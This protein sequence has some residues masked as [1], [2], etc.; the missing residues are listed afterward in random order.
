MK[1]K[2]ILHDWKPARGA[3]ALLTAM[4]CAVLLI[5][6]LR[7]AYADTADIPFTE[8]VGEKPSDKGA[9]EDVPDAEVGETEA[10]AEEAPAEEAGETKAPAADESAEDEEFYEE[11]ADSP[12]LFGASAGVE[13]GD[14][15]SYV[16][17]AGD[18]EDETYSVPEGSA[19]IY[20]IGQNV[21]Y[22]NDATKG[23]AIQQGI[24]AALTYI[25]GLYDNDDESTVER[26]ATIVVSKGTYENGIDIGAESSSELSVSQLLKDILIK[27]SECDASDDKLT[28]R[29]VA[30]DAV[31]WNDDGTIAGFNSSSSGEV[32]LEGNVDVIADDMNL[33][34][35]LAGLYYSTRGLI[36]A[37]GLDSLSVIGTEKD[38]YIRINASDISES[39]YV[40]TGDGDD[41]VNMIVSSRADVEADITTVIQI[42]AALRALDELDDTSITEKLASIIFPEGMTDTEQRIADALDKMKQLRTKL[43]ESAYAAAKTTVSVNA[44]SGSDIIDIILKDSTRIESE[45]ITGSDITATLEDGTVVPLSY[46]TK[47]A[48]YVDTGAFELNVDGGSG[49]DRI[50]ISGERDSSNAYPLAKAASEYVLDTIKNNGGA[51]TESSISILGGAGDDVITVDNSVMFSTRGTTTVTTAGGSGYDRLHL[52]GRLD[53]NEEAENRISYKQLGNGAEFT[54][55][56]LA[57]IT[58]SDGYTNIDYNLGYTGAYTIIASDMDAYTDTLENKRTVNIKDIAEGIKENAESFTNYV[59][60]VGTDKAHTVDF[61]SSDYILVEDGTRLILSNIYVIGGEDELI[62][63]KKLIAP[64]F[65]IIIDGDKIEIEGQ[66]SGSSIL[67]NAYAEDKAIVEIDASL[68]VDTG[69]D[70]DGLP[71]DVGV[72]GATVG[73][74][75]EKRSI[76]INVGEQAKILADGA[77]DIMARLY[78]YHDFVP[79][80]ELLKKNEDGSSSIEFNPVTAKE[81][82][83]NIN[84]GGTIHAR[85]SIHINADV[86]IDIDVTNGELKVIIPIAIGVIKGEAKINVYG[87]AD[88]RSGLDEADIY[89]EEKADSD[90]LPTHDAGILLRADGTMRITAHAGAGVLKFNVSIAAAEFET[91]V[92]VGG[93]ARLVAGDS[94]RL[95]AKSHLVTGVSSVGYASNKFNVDPQSGVFISGTIIEL[96]SS[97]AVNDKASITA[98]LGDVEISSISRVSNTTVSVAIPTQTESSK[99]QLTVFK[100]IDL[101]KKLLSSGSEGGAL[102]S[103]AEKAGF[104]KLGELFTKGTESSNEDGKQPNQLLGA[105]AFA[106][107]NVGSTANVETDG[108]IEAKK[109]LNVYSLSEVRSE[110][111]A[112]GSLYRTPNIV[113]SKTFEEVPN[114][115]IGAGL[116]LAIVENSASSA[117]KK[118]NVNAG[119]LNISAQLGSSESVAVAKSGHVPEDKKASLGIAGAISV[120]IA[121]FENGAL[122]GKD[123]VCTISDGGSINVTALGTGRFVT[124]GDASGKRMRSMVDMGAVK[125]P[126]QSDYNGGENFKAIGAGIAVDVIN[127]D[128]RAEIED[129]AIIKTA[130]GRLGG[131][132]MRAEFSGTHHIEAA[133]GAEGGTS[134]IPVLSLSLSGVNVTAYIGSD[135]T[136]AFIVTDGDINVNATNNMTRTLVA[137]AQAAGVKVGLGAA[138]GIIVASDNVEASLCRSVNALGNVYVDAVSIS[139]ISEDVRASARGIKP[140]SGSGS[141]GQG[142]GTTGSATQEDV[143]KLISGNTTASGESLSVGGVDSTINKLISTLKGLGEKLP[144]GKNTNLS[145]STIDSLG[146]SRPAAGTSEGNVQA[147]AAVAVNVFQNSVSSKIG[148]GT[149]I[150]A[151]KNVRASSKQDSDSAISANG[152]AVRAKEGIGAAVAVNYIKY[153]NRAVVRA[154]KVSAGGSILVSAS[155]EEDEEK[156]AAEEILSDLVKYFANQNGIEVLLD[157][158]AKSQNKTADELMDDLIKEHH[159]DYASLSDADKKAVADE[160]T[161]MLIA[162]LKD[163]P[164]DTAVTLASDIMD[165][166]L[167]EFTELFSIEF[168]IDLLLDN[169]DA[170]ATLEQKFNELK[171]DAKMTLASLRELISSLLT[172]KFGNSSEIDGIGNRISTVAISGEGASNVGVA[173]SVAVTNVDGETLA[174]ISERASLSDDDI[175]SDGTVTVKSDSADKVYTTATASTVANGAPDKNTTTDNS[176]NKSIGIG[177]S[178]ALSITNTESNAIIGANRSIVASALGVKAYLQND[179]DTIA[180]AGQDPIGAQQKTAETT[181][182]AGAAASI[183]DANNSTP[184]DIAADAAVAITIADNTV[185]A[186]VQKGKLNLT[187]GNILNSE[188]EPSKAVNGEELQNLIA[189][190]YQRGQTMTVSSGFA[191]AKKAAVGASV[192]LNI[193]SSDVAA[194]LEGTGNIKG[195]ILVDSLTFNE[196]EVNALAVVTGVNLDRYLSK[197]RS[198]VD[199]GNTL[200]KPSTGSINAMAMNKINEKMGKGSENDANSS[201]PISASLLQKLNIKTPEV[202]GDKKASDALE[203]NSGSTNGAKPQDYDPSGNGQSINI[204][205]AVGVNITNHKSTAK[206]NGDFNVAKAEIAS[207]N[208]GNFRT[209]GSGATITP[210]TVGSNNIAAGVAVSVNNNRTNAIL[211]GKLDANG[212]RLTINAVSTANMDGKYP[213]LMAAQALAG[214]V[215]GSGGKVGL[216]GA[217]AVTV[218]Q[219]EI[220]AYTL[221]NTELYAGDIAI[222]ANDKSKLAVRAGA[223]SVN[224]STVGMGASFA[225]LYADNE[226]GAAVGNNNSVTAESLTINAERM[227]VTSDDYKFPFDWDTLFTANVADD[228]ANNKGLININ[229]SDGKGNGDDSIEVNLSFDDLLKTVDMLNYLTMTNYYVE[230]IAGGISTGATAKVGLAGGVSMIYATGKTAAQIGNNSKIELGGK[231]DM[232]A[233]SDITVR[234]IGGSVGA[235]MQAGVGVNMAG[236]VNVRERT[237]YDENGN[238]VKET[239]S[240]QTLATV[241]RSTSISAKSGIDIDASAHIELV[242]ATVAAGLAAGNG[243]GTTGGNLNVIATGNTVRAAVGESSELTSEKG[244]VNVHANNESLLLPVAASVTGGSAKVAAGGT[245]STIVT[246]NVTEAKLGSGVTVDAFESVSIKAESREKLINWLSSTSA[247]TGASVAGTIG[248]IVSGSKTLAEVGNNATVKSN[249]GSIEVLAN[250][251]VLQVVVLTAATVSGGGNLAA[252]ATVNVSVFEREVAAYVGQNASLVAGALS[253]GKNV[254]IVANG[255]DR[256]YLITAAGSAGTSSTISGN[257][258]TVV[259]KSTVKAEADSSSYIEAGDTVVIFAD[260]DYRIYDIAPTVAAGTGTASVGATAST[261]VATNTVKANVGS[262]ATIIA[263]A[264]SNAANGGYT[265][266]NKRRRG[267][268]VKANAK[269][270]TVKA[271]VGVAATGGSVAVAGVVSTFVSKNTVCAAVDTGATLI[272]GFESAKDN[273]AASGEDAEASAEADDD[274]DL[275]IVAGAIGGASST[276]VGASVVTVVMNRS[277]TASINASTVRATGSVNAAANAE[278]M[279]V[280]ASLNVSGA[281]TASVAAGANTL[282]YNND[283]K[284]YLTGSIYAK[285]DVKVSSYGKVDL[286]LAAGCAGG[287]GTVAVTGGASALVFKNNVT[288]ELG[289]TV[290]ADNI[291]VD[292]QSDV[293]LVNAAGAVGGAGTAGITPVAVVTYYNGT[294]QAL[295]S[296]GS[297]IDAKGSFKLNG[298]S[299]ETVT[300][301]A[302]GAAIAGTAGV[303]GTVAVS[304]TKQTTRAKAGS[305]VS[306]SASAIDV[307]ALDTSKFITA[308]GSVAGAGTT[309][310]G[311]VA[312]VTIMH[313]TVEAALTGGSDS[314]KNAVTSRTGS[315]NITADAKRDIRAYA[316]DVAGSGIA[317]VSP[318]VMVLVTGGKMDK[319]SAETLS[320]GFSGSDFNTALFGDGNEYTKAY[321]MDDLDEL[322]SGEQ[323]YSDIQIGDENGKADF[324][325]GYRSDDFDNDDFDDNTNTG[326]GENYEVKPEGNGEISSVEGILNEKYSFNPKDSV[327]ALVGSGVHIVS[328]LDILVSAKDTVQAEMFNASVAG[329]GVAAVGVGLSTAVLYSNVVAG[330]DEGAAL[331]ADGDIT[332]SAYSGSKEYENETDDVIRNSAVSDMLSG[333]SD[334]E[335]DI[336]KR[337]IRVVSISASGSGIAGVAVAGSALSLSNITTAYMNADVTR[338]NELCVSAASLYPNTIA[339]NGSIGGGTV[340]VSAS[341]AVAVT[342]GEVSASIGGN[343]S[344]TNVSK[345]NVTTSAV[346]DTVSASAAIS[347]GAAAVNG[348]IAV[349]VNRMK[350][351]TY[352]GNAVSISSAKEVNVSAVNTSRGRAYILGVSGGGVGA[353][354][355]AAVV[356]AS[357]EINTYVGAKPNSSE[358]C[359]N[360]VAADK[361]SIT[362]TVISSA[363]PEVIMASGGAV[364]ATGTVLAVVNNTKSLAAILKKNVTAKSID[365]SASLTA[366]AEASFDSATIG[367]TAM[368]ASIA[369]VGLNSKNEATVDTTG[370]VISVTAGNISVSANGTTNAA[371]QSAVVSAGSSTINGNAAIVDNHSTNTAEIKGGSADKTELDVEGNVNVTATGIATANAKITG[372]SLAQSSTVNGSFAVAVLRNAQRAAIEAG[373]INANSVSVTSTLNEVDDNDENADAKKDTATATIVAG[374]GT[375][376]VNASAN[377]AVAYGKSESS[378]EIKAKRIDASGSV[379]VA[380]SGNAGALAKIDSMNVGSITGAFMAGFAYAQGKF[381]AVIDLDE[382]AALNANTVNV[383]AKDILTRAN[384]LVTPAGK[385][386]ASIIGIKTNLAVAIA[387]AK[388]NALIRGK[389][390]VASEGNVSVLAQSTS[391]AKAAINKPAVEVSNATVA[392]NVAV[393]LLKTE[394]KAAAGGNKISAPKATLSVVSRLNQNYS[395]YT[396]LATA[397]GNKAAVAMRSAKANAI[398]AR[399]IA[400]NTASIE[401][402]VDAN[403][404]EVKAYGKS[405]AYAMPGSAALEADFAG[406]G[407]NAVYAEA[408]GTF[409]AEIN[410]SGKTVKAGTG[411]I[412]MLNEYTAKAKA[413]SGQPTGGIKASISALNIKTNVAE[414]KS[415]VLASTVISAGN[416]ESDGII[417]M[418]AK[419]TATAEA[420][421]NAS[422]IEIS[423][424]TVAVNVV[425]ATLE[426]EQNVSISGGS[427]SAEGDITLDSEFNNNATEYD[428]LATVGSNS[429]NSI[430]IAYGTIKQNTADANVKTEVSAAVS[431]GSV[432]TKGLLHVKTV[433]RSRA[434]ANVNTGSEISAK[435]VEVLVTNANALGTFIAQAKT[436]DGSITASGVEVLV[437]SVTKAYASTSV[438]GDLGA[439][440]TDVSYNTA[441]SDTSST[442]SAIFGGNGTIKGNVTVSATGNVTSVAETQHPTISVSMTRIAATKT[443]AKLNAVQSAYVDNT[444]AMSVHGS[445]DIDSILTGNASSD[446]GGAQIKNKNVV[447][448]GFTVD[449]VSMVAADVNESSAISSTSNKAY[450]TS[451]N[452]KGSVEARTVSID[453]LSTVN[454]SSTTKKGVDLALASVGGLRSSA[455]TADSVSAYAEKIAIDADDL[456]INANGVAT[457]NAESNALGSASA[458]SASVSEVSAGVG[459]G[460]GERNAETGELKLGTGAQTV[461]AG[462]GDNA[463]ITLSGDLTVKAINKGTAKAVLIKGL[464]ISVL[465]FTK[466]CLPTKS[467]YETEAYIGNGS[468]INVGGNVTVE[469]KDDAKATSEA[470]S[471]DIAFS[472]SVT[473][474]YGSNTVYAKNTAKVGTSSIFAAKDIVIKSF[475]KADM[476]A[477]TVANSSG[478]FTNEGDLKAENKLTRSTIANV[479]DGASIESDFGNITVLAQSGTED[480][481]STYAKLDGLAFTDFKHTRAETAIDSE[482]RIDIGNAKITDT[483]GTVQIWADASLDELNT[484]GYAY[485]SG[486]GAE[487]NAKAKDNISLRPVVTIKGSGSYTCEI[488]ARNVEIH[489][490]TTKLG[491]ESFSEAS[492]KAFGANVDAETDLDVTLDGDVTIE[493][494]RL[495]AY[496][497]LNVTASSAPEYSTHNIFG[498]SKIFL[499]AIGHGVA[500][501]DMDIVSNND[502]TVK[503]GVAIHGASV[504]LRGM[505]YSGTSDY[506]RDTSGFT[507]KQKKGNVNR[508][509]NAGTSVD[510]N[511]RFYIGDAAAGIVIDI[512]ESEGKTLVRQVGIKDEKSIWIISADKV[513]I[514]RITNNKAGSL[515]MDVTS[516]KYEYVYDQSY[517]PY[518][519]IVNRTDKTVEIGGVTV[520]NDNFINPRVTLLGGSYT[521]KN[522]DITR[523][524]VSVTNR[525]SGSVSITGL[526]ANPRGSVAFE[527]VGKDKSGNALGGSLTSVSAITNNSSGTLTAPIWAHSL[528]IKGAS[529]V[530]SSENARFAL[531]LITY[532]SNETDAELK[533]EAT[534]SID[535]SGDVFIS[536]T[537]ILMKVVSSDDWAK[538]QPSKAEFEP[539]MSIE[540]IESL[541]KVDV[542]LETGKRVY[543]L[544]GTT[545]VTMPIPGT[546]EYVSDALK[547]LSQSVTIADRDKLEYYLESYDFAT[548]VSIYLLPNGTRIYVDSDGE[549]IRIR[550]NNIDFGLADYKYDPTTNTVTLA[551]GV[552][553]DL[554]NGTLSVKEGYSYEALL[555]AISGN[556]LMNKANGGTF[557]FI[558]LDPEV[559]DKVVYDENGNITNKDEFEGTAAQVTTLT[560]WYE[561]NGIVYFYASLG[562]AAGDIISASKGTKNYILAYDAAKDTVKAYLLSAQGSGVNSDVN[563]EDFGFEVNKD[564]YYTKDSDKSTLDYWGE[565]SIDVIIRNFPDKDKNNNKLYDAENKVINTVYYVVE[566]DD[567]Y[568]PNKSYDTVYTFSQ[569]I[570]VS[571]SKIKYDEAS[572]KWYANSK[573]LAEVI[574]FGSGSFGISP[575]AASKTDDSELKAVYEALAGMYWKIS[576]EDGASYRMN[577]AVITGNLDSEN[578]RTYYSYN[579]NVE[580]PSYIN[581]TTLYSY[582][583]K[584]TYA[585]L[586]EI[587]LTLTPAQTELDENGDVIANDYT[588]EIRFDASS[589]GGMTIVG[590]TDGIVVKETALPANNRTDS[591]TAY[592]ITSSLYI[593]KSTDASENG[594]ALIFATGSD[595]ETISMANGK[596]AFAAAYNSV[597]GK[598]ESETVTVERLASATAGMNSKITIKRYDTSNGATKAQNVMLESVTGTE[599]GAVAKDI[600]GRYYIYNSSDSTWTLLTSSTSYAYNQNN[601]VIDKT[602]DDKT[603]SATVAT[604][605]IKQSGSTVLT[606]KEVKLELKFICTTAEG[607]LAMRTVNGSDEYYILNNGKWSSIQKDEAEQLTSSLTSSSNT[608]NMTLATYVIFTD[609]MEVGSDGSVTVKNK[610]SLTQRVQDVSGIKYNMGDI[611]GSSVT[612][613]MKDTQGSIID[614]NDTA[615]DKAMN[616]TA[617]KGDI[618]FVSASSGSIGT[619]DNPLELSAKGQIRYKNLSGKDSLETDTF[620]SGDGDI[621]LGDIVVDGLGELGG[622]KLYIST[623]SGKISFGSM[624]VMRGG[625]VKLSAS[626]D[627]VARK[628]INITTAVAGEN[629][630]SYASLKGKN[631]LLDAVNLYDNSRLTLEANEKVIIDSLTTD[632]H[633]GKAQVNI[634]AGDSVTVDEYAS[635][636]DSSVTVS[637]DED[638]VLG[639]N[640]TA[641]ASDLDID[642]K[643]SI[644]LKNADVKRGSLDADS[645][646]DLTFGIIETENNT[647]KLSAKGNIAS[648]LENGYIYFRHGERNATFTLSANGNIGA[649]ERYLVTDTDSTVNITLAHDYYIDSVELVGST[650]YERT[651]RSV[652]TSSGRDELGAW[653]TGELILSGA[654]K[655]T[656]YGELGIDANEAIADMVVSREER[657]NWIDILDT[658]ALMAL[659]KDGSITRDALKE[660]IGA[661]AASKI[662]SLIRLGDTVDDEKGE[663]GYEQLAKLLEARLG[664]KD[665]GTD[666]YIISDEVIKAYLTLSMNLDNV[667]I[668]RMA[669]IL[670]GIVNADE[671]AEMIKAAWDKA[672]YGKH[673]GTRP[674]D[675]EP[676]EIRIIVGESTGAAYVKNEGD[677]I[678]H[679]QNGT[680][681]AGEVTSA[682]GNVTVAAALGAVE[683]SGEGTANITGNVIDISAKLGVGANTQLIID[684]QKLDMTLVANVTKPTDRADTLIKP[685]DEN[686]M[687]TSEANKTVSPVKGWALE[688]EI[689]YDWIRAKNSECATRLNIAAGGDINVAEDS[690]DL[691]LG[692]IKTSNGSI[693][694][695]AQGSIVDTREN[696][697][698]PNIAANGDVQLTSKEGGI[699]TEN[700]RINTDIG[701]T[702]HAEA[703]DDISISDEGTLDMV[704]D[705]EQGQINAD[706]K[707]DLNLSNTEGDLVIGPIE[708][709]GTVTIVSEG[710]IVAGDKYD[711]EAQIKANTIILTAKGGIGTEDEAMSVDTDGENGGT[712]SAKGEYINITEVNGKLILKNIDS[713]T[714][715]V[716][717][718]RGD[719]LDGN[720]AICDDAVEAQKEANNARAEADAAEADAFVKSEKAKR[721]RKELDKAKSESDAQNAVV[722]ELERQLDDAREELNNT[723]PADT[724]KVKELN[725]RIEKLEKQLDE[726]KNRQAQL[727]DALDKANAENDAAQAE[728]DKANANAEKLR[729]EAEAKQAEADRIKAEAEN[730][731]ATVNA[732]NDVTISA[733]GNIGEDGHGV[734]ISAGGT[735][736]VSA[737]ADVDGDGTPDGNGK[738]IFIAGKGDIDISDITT[739][740]HV[741]IA[742]VG[743]S[744]SG[745]GKITADSLDISSV[746]GDVGSEDAPIHTSVD[747]LDAMGENVY[748]HND[749]DTEIGQISA[750]DNIKLDSD[751]DVTADSTAKPNIIAADTTINASGDIGTADTPLDTSTGAF[752]GTADDIYIN[753]HTKDLDLSDIEADKLD[754]DTDGNVTGK[755][756]HVKD[757]T[758][759]ADGYVGSEDDPFTFEASGKTDIN[760]DL[761][762]WYKNLYTS[763]E[764]DR[765]IVT[766]VMRFETRINGE[767]YNVYA[768]IRVDSFGG[769]R[770][771]GF[772]LNKGD[773][774]EVFWYKVLGLIR[775]YLHITDFGTFVFCSEDEA[776]FEN[777]AAWAKLFSYLRMC[778]RAYGFGL[779][780][781]N[782]NDMHLDSALKEAWV[783]DPFAYFGKMTDASDEAWAKLIGQLSEELS[784]FDASVNKTLKGGFDSPKELYKA[785]NECMAAFTEKR[786]A[787][788]NLSRPYSVGIPA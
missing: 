486:L 4:L 685:I 497:S 144:V 124:V 115:A 432:N 135:P 758:I 274:S 57:D 754:V 230:A 381:N 92:S 593:K 165:A 334:S 32:L 440:Y 86:D 163:E 485:A 569:F 557:S 414:A 689:A 370:A 780:V 730:A 455:H 479:A 366:E 612:V 772:F 286:A 537:P 433:G 69:L 158:A 43:A 192:A 26:V 751:G 535:A 451:S 235:S 224:G 263:H 252:G 484:Y 567:G 638:V 525:S 448:S 594:M 478:G 333:V 620:I 237:Y 687:P 116:A 624:D 560:K 63:V 719:I 217:V 453:A 369:Y 278:D 442:T 47:L 85:G 500:K 384:A 507:V 402:G 275:Y 308:V 300:T 660:Y 445:V 301:D 372:I 428:A 183:K 167:N 434:K 668:D 75:E 174:E 590:K 350:A 273:A 610:E 419:G 728:A 563:R 24:E 335:L 114:K 416:V 89:N 630:Y 410:A 122:I 316:L 655:D 259:S 521:V 779:A 784:A 181:P 207:T 76:Y 681:T 549:I 688:V 19:Y 201:L 678:I 23:N 591:G 325:S 533:K 422:D 321:A 506:K 737:G 368:G 623:E 462:I 198:I 6:P 775:Y 584:F 407:V 746:G 221:E 540:H 104:D 770:L 295:V 774:D 727:N 362:N 658:P 408:A 488:T 564:N 635:L 251:D 134:I 227:K 202:S 267:I 639:G 293:L 592:R 64:D 22:N 361:L 41:T 94:A 349:S 101:V 229:V 149:V 332:V 704:A 245:L 435:N 120:H 142:D 127:V 651:K 154:N 184:D 97:A 745:N 400:K 218:A 517:I 256:A 351:N 611:T 577:T 289:G 539:S 79:G 164:A 336:T 562:T 724:A 696:E 629:E 734:S 493:N 36:D 632:G 464:G 166:I 585:S 679:Q 615:T 337:T 354:V 760:G 312:S 391:Y 110:V 95:I 643:G 168:F 394:Q 228:D 306:I 102:S 329:S 10:P 136:G 58:I 344:I 436:T 123:A 318:T 700:E 59:V 531:W 197:L 553:F 732:E 509:F 716:I 565:G 375:I 17:G 447:V 625:A 371:A 403:R 35:M 439:G 138:V 490:K 648:T 395:S 597:M 711:R 53:K 206:V 578:N 170:R 338:A 226:I 647:L 195:S 765:S 277:V 13:G 616:I 495:R 763:M 81:G 645:G 14:E 633:G 392:A 471:K 52:S 49:D 363:K 211:G 739:D 313:N 353:G 199:L 326:R 160:V 34:L 40:D 757:I 418:D 423:G 768:L 260:L 25:K 265:I 376:G 411:G 477:G 544:E 139:R 609:G 761:G 515:T 270:L 491:I 190:A 602:T 742:T 328:A 744:I 152:S 427:V 129:G 215:G 78:L 487:P 747:H 573:E 30:E 180:V 743:G 720:D 33:E 673:E 670:S 782:K 767:R 709:L 186:K 644:S 735:I 665:E 397:A 659:I 255:K 188:L 179:I 330:V 12:A 686:G 87:N 90:K 309:A 663:S 45:E 74:Y 582:Y 718:A 546:L 213:G 203:S 380:S 399:N 646:S 31:E 250:G 103:I 72:D 51:V 752:H 210:G 345:V 558:Y 155:I 339:A 652:T 466:S 297:V 574:S 42:D 683:G 461:K 219:A 715:A 723:D 117:V 62:T 786:R 520:H 311:V 133:A 514:A 44:G 310:V 314:V 126:L 450:I 676:R 280:I 107:I 473:T 465:N 276:G 159:S 143:E 600:Q 113:S 649:R 238:E 472:V 571:G 285:K 513:T 556:W 386:D 82:Y 738:D 756:I 7:T 204:A 426:G 545:T 516:G 508:T 599:N 589:S 764:Y 189:Q 492:A 196:D 244:A 91:A 305:D 298:E 702:L 712:L 469:S 99:E 73:L 406:I 205:A 523:S 185:H 437:D 148:D 489:T 766:L 282:V 281:G 536:V 240:D 212:G 341:I 9:E 547:G 264:V 236:I 458:V 209:L 93:N 268:I 156:R 476:T 262:G 130:D 568:A 360:T 680:L 27:R 750:K 348:G 595:G 548:G 705:S 431:G 661:D 656:V 173:G 105:F 220:N 21:I 118:G 483:F 222:N 542:V 654:A 653:Q 642:A 299:R 287:A 153:I 692:V 96:S 182:E 684:Q 543:Q 510:S 266:G 387:N 272:A 70:G 80:L 125:V 141:Y 413:V 358:T 385:V 522:T 352:I 468:S 449:S 55:K 634:T 482:S 480:S 454:A 417:D 627:I 753:N 714:D 214:S 304:V 502:V 171:L 570:T 662:D 162:S 441:K 604:T 470:V 773:A 216:A 425:E 54:V 452:G 608:V 559:A 291:S 601:V 346:F 498:R 628:A 412:I 621:E 177:A 225:V 771:L 731:D 290:N 242:S 319:D 504:T 294:A 657:E 231:L 467:S 194:L 5:L 140:A 787:W 703:K 61:D 223:L 519:R 191:V 248:V 327:S 382:E 619:E 284:A 674:G 302:I 691:G 38:D 671:I 713:D 303:S 626:G 150:I 613:T 404:I 258:P 359:K 320:G 552:V 446:V 580:Y 343:A 234:Q 239:S 20:E 340:G 741:G 112:D 701:G 637:A 176:A 317:A 551:E 494:A 246:E 187:G 527:W 474:V 88:I 365:V 37:N 781:L 151:G 532:D 247:S 331:E 534:L 147:A 145:G 243:R 561:K 572:G 579:T 342:K 496:D 420:I 555:S 575:D 524:E 607:I 675:T 699:G 271:S 405:N 528:S 529:N 721:T 178:F 429:G 617:A 586:A 1:A 3:A 443:T 28:L 347:G 777:G 783:F 175:S 356:V 46:L 292:A 666:A 583:Y 398:I 8:E 15:S 253:D 511:T 725:A 606:I 18:V 769:M 505:A 169:D 283:V 695:T 307:N 475:S 393:A 157:A 232:D 690:G 261:L 682:R 708:A 355:S 121:S 109:A 518:V 694:L 622:T 726:A 762:A 603:N 2:N 669:E 733:G 296:S 409:T 501:V 503:S 785:L 722:A 161:N 788:E 39:V 193:V 456:S 664:A 377:I 111:R 68:R 614:A 108:S 200:D 254:I 736:N 269:G 401:G 374:S 288:A 759:D 538:L 576:R 566:S 749:K 16:T 378:A 605:V 50:S 755:D 67:I 424:V 526:I 60:E 65:N 554:V 233:A 146:S 588:H 77:V 693:A 48:V 322:L 106:Y 677:I 83:A 379:K 367:G 598:Y 257:I 421:I 119:E 740:G 650:V 71:S 66:L 364:G 208:R 550:E 729:N 697:T 137:D 672:D 132:D 631:I 459:S 463:K 430:S 389:G 717:S 457:A 390:E 128:T 315:V 357:A 415:G 640:I 131:V 596:A 460:S 84:I 499:G 778:K 530:G 748:I 641:D 444:G 29:I 383:E 541:G 710:S 100:G 587:G 698:E 706:A 667:D 396:A 172:D 438:S 512:Y 636:T 373:T 618:T 323:R 11:E 581:N 481:I 249:N 279:N 98:I 324:E 776:D 388:I 241:G 707:L 56:A